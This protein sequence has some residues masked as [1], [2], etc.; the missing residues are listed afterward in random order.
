MGWAT[1]KVTASARASGWLTA[2]DWVSASGLALV[3]A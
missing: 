2:W 3:W 1:A